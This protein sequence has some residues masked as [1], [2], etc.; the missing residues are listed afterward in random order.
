MVNKSFYA[1]VA[2]GIALMLI[3]IT[4]TET[5]LATGNIT[6]T[7]GNLYLT[8]AGDSVL[9]YSDNTVGLGASD[10]RWRDVNAVE[11]RSY[12]VSVNTIDSS[13]G[14]MVYVGKTGSAPTL[15]LQPMNSVFEGGEMRLAGSGNYSTWVFDNFKGTLRF[16]TSNG[17]THTVSADGE[18]IKGYVRPLSNNLYD[19][20]DSTYKWRSVY[21][22]QLRLTPTAATPACQNGVM[23]VTGANQLKICLNGAW[24]TVQVA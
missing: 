24:K 22:Y 14:A 5:V 2:S 21:V 10:V 1:G 13:S 11:I 17:T 19:L 9:P 18:T 23:Y 8:P 16:F 12:N 15:I 20:G 4:V 7:S 3:A 6:T